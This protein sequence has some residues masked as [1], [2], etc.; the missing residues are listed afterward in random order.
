M[1][2]IHNGVE[3]L[4]PEDLFDDFRRTLKDGSGSKEFE[5]GPQDKEP[6]EPF[7][8]DPKELDI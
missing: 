6:K 1:S 4:W 8:F 2:T 3:S 5:K 7:L